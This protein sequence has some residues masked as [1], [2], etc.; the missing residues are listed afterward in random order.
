[1]GRLQGG[2]LALVAYARREIDAETALDRVCDA[3]AASVATIRCVLATADPTRI[4]VIAG[5]ADENERRVLADAVADARGLRLFRTR[6]SGELRSD[7]ELPGYADWIAVEPIT[8][9]KGQLLGLLAAMGSDADRDDV[10]PILPSAGLFCSQI[11]F[12]ILWLRRLSRQMHKFNNALA[13][14]AANV[15]H[16]AAL[17]STEE[18]PRSGASREL[19]AASGYAVSNLTELLA[20]GRDLNDVLFHPRRSS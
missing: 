6:A 10:L 9:R 19:V 13:A 2:E 3:V 16:V 14:V 1:M 12:E 8:T 17:L 7:T 11:G 4:E 20:A 15:E 5:A 18:A